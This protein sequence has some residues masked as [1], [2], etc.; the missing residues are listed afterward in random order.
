[1][2]SFA[3]P[4]PHW[5]QLHYVPGCKS[6][7]MEVAPCLLVCPCMPCSIKYLPAHGYSSRCHL[8][9][10]LNLFAFALDAGG[11]SK[12]GEFIADDATY[13]VGHGI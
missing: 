10:D 6:K 9:N 8:L 1:M 5:M 11:V 12:A 2:V 3:P 4:S 7:K 13:R